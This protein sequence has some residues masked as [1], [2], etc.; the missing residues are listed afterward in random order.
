MYKQITSEIRPQLDRTPEEMD[1]I[2]QR[3]R[4][5]CAEHT[6]THTH[7]HHMMSYT[8]ITLLSFNA[9]LAA[10]IW[11]GAKSAVSE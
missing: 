11:N 3:G 8:L 4:L 7:T 9:S 5:V 6:H 2:E 10:V 1:K